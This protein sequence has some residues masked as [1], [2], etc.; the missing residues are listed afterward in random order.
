RVPTITLLLPVRVYWPVISRAILPPYPWHTGA[1][2]G[3]IL[4][5]HQVDIFWLLRPMGGWIPMRTVESGGSIPLTGLD[6]GWNCQNWVLA[7]STRVG[8][9]LTDNPCPPEHFN[10]LS[11]RMS[12]LR[13][14]VRPLQDMP[15]RGR[16]FC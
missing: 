9:R 14:V 10:R 15:F 16:I 12:P 2:L 7:G 1:L 8:P 5:L 13:I 3:R 11:T 4:H 6:E